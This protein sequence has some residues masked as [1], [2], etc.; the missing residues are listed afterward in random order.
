MGL[1]YSVMSYFYGT[2]TSISPEQIRLSAQRLAHG[3]KLK[4][5]KIQNANQDLET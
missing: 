3:L 1:L 4:M 2:Q 5:A